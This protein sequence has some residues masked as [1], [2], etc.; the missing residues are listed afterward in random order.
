MSK[1]RSTV[2]V[3][4]LAALAL[5]GCAKEDKEA[6]PAPRLSASKLK[7]ARATAV[8]T[9]T[10]EYGSSIALSRNPTWADAPALTADPFTAAFGTDV[11]LE[12]GDNVF[13]ATA[14]DAAKNVS[15]AGTLTITR[16]AVAPT[17]LKL[18]LSASAS[19]ADEA[20]V[21]AL[22][23]LGVDEAVD[24]ENLQ[25][26]FSAQHEEATLPP[27]TLSAKAD[28]QGRVR[29][30]LTGLTRAGIWTITATSSD[31]VKVS[32]QARFTVKAGA[33][34]H[35]TLTLE[36]TD[37]AGQP[38]SGKSITVPAGASIKAALTLTDVAENVIDAPVA[39]Y[40]DAPGALVAGDLIANVTAARADPGYTVVAV[41]QGANGA[42]GKPVS[43]TAHFIVVPGTAQKIALSL[44]SSSVK[45][46]ER[47]QLSSTVT[48]AYG[49]DVLAGSS[50]APAYASAPALATSF[51]PPG[52]A[53][54]LTQG[55]LGDATFV[56]FDLSAVKADGYLFDLTATYGTG[57][58]ALTA[59][60]WLTVE[61]A[62]AA[63]FKLV[64]DP[65]NPGTQ[66]QDFLF[67]TGCAGG[68]AR[69][70]SASVLAGED[71]G[72]EY[73][74][75]DLY[76]ND[77]VGPTKVVTN[78]PGALVL[79]DGASGAGRISSLT[80]SRAAAF[81]VTGYITGV[82]GG[83]KRSL[84][85]GVGPAAT[86]SVSLSST[87]VPHNTAVKAIA[88]VR[89]GF[90]NLVDCPPGATVDPSVFAF[91][92]TPA[93]ATA[94]AVTCLAGAFSATFT[95]GVENA[96]AIE[97]TYR[98]GPISGMAYVNV[99]GFDNAPPSIAIQNVLVNGSPCAAGATAGS[100]AV[101]PNDTVDFDAVA[102]DNLS[103]AQVSYSVFF[104]TTQTLR[105][106]SVLISSDQAL[107]V[108]IHFTFRVPNNVL[109]E[110]TP[111]VAQA[112]DGAGNQKNSAALLLNARMTAAGTGGRALTTVSAGGLVT[113][114]VDVA[115]RAS[116]GDVVVVNEGQNGSGGYDL[117]KVASG[118]TSLLTTLTSRPAFAAA[119][120]TGRLFVSDTGQRVYRVSADGLTV[121]QSPALA[122]GPAGLAMSAA[123][124]QR[125]WVDLTNAQDGDQLVLDAGQATA[126]TFELDNNGA[127]AA[128]AGKTCVTWTGA[129]ANAAAALASAINGAAGLRARAISSNGSARV[130]LE[131][132]ATGE[133]GTASP[134]IALQRSTANLGLSGLSGNTGTL[135]DG[136]DADLWVGSRSS[137][138]VLRYQP[139]ATTFL[140]ATHGSFNPNQPLLG[141]AVRD[142][143]AAGGDNSYDYG[144]FF[145]D[146][147][148]Q[149]I[150]VRRASGF[151]STTANL[152]ATTNLYAITQAS[153]GTNFNALRDVV[154][155]SSGCLLISEE[156]DGGTGINRGAI[157]AANVSGSGAPT[158][159]IQ[160]ARGFA[161]VRGL[162]LDGS[163]HLLIADRDANVVYRL[164]PL[165]S[166]PAGACF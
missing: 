26:D 155:T 158:S 11:P 115:W 119:D 32:D 138:T 103:L 42:S 104:S 64:D 139:A 146:Q 8:L 36:S 106:R 33:P 164:A 46:G 99:V 137:N 29:A 162:A 68:A 123:S 56:A 118:T 40:T 82:G 90:G 7:T 120:A 31:A 156:D 38:T 128:A 136:H 141:L 145:V 44:S 21:D 60:A 93:A 125:G 80:V 47:V 79:D 150:N 148:Q 149:Q 1:L 129:G 72:Y 25:V 30:T 135:A 109:P 143:W 102:S 113:A 88:V 152:A 122:Y 86:V 69:C 85:V 77:R 75:V 101:W 53:Q 19:S 95:F 140:S 105:N 23:E 108:T 66:I 73:Q 48:D 24:L 98:A 67:T 16:I 65:A 71:V 100:C 52:G 57:A 116:T 10:A 121:D 12:L 154:L 89:D 6:P 81:D 114:P 161:G 117:L 76:G 28:A 50:T 78:A 49:N 147:G 131:A 15:E 45:A 58:S 87:L 17:R 111:L 112:I 43:D 134:A 144:L 133:P 55:F 142:Q 9:G 127:C 97:G 54:P 132:L 63:G 165:S 13:T 61:P 35:L 39:L 159:V 91:A 5:A 110:E 83:L 18:T 107:P 51:T 96:Y 157:Y 153:A 4:A 3:A 84:S 70:A 124:P 160:V 2:V 130:S 62:A 22:A 163:G 27:V 20:Q 14:T 34:A 166:P 74:V 92:A 94:S 59:H 41:V 37:P 151:N 126:R